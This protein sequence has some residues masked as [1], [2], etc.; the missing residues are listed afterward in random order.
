MDSRTCK[1]CGLEKGPD[2]FHSKMASNGKRYWAHQCKECVKPMAR[3]RKEKWYYDDPERARADSK[4]WYIENRGKALKAMK[5]YRV[6]RVHWFKWYHKQWRGKN[7]S[8]V[9]A[10]CRQ[11]QAAKIQATPAWAD[12]DKILLIYEQARAASLEVDHIVPL[13]SP[14]VCGLHVEHNLRSILPDANNK[15]GN[16]WWPD[17]P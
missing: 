15:K 4:K 7:P 1:M 8:K 11:Y 12:R 9:L 14:L 17:M 13:R 2:G 10:W 16:R 6:A 5:E 3:Q